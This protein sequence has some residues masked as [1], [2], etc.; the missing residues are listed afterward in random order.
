MTHAASQ[1]VKVYV[2]VLASFDTDG[3]LRP[4]ALLWEDG[5]R[6]RID[7]VLDVRSAASLRAGGQ[8][9]RYTIRVGDRES[10]LYFE[11]SPSLSGNGLGRWFVERRAPRA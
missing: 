7:R 9:D 6:Y 11:R 5:R 10:Y 8:G 4:L 2:H 1:S 3:R